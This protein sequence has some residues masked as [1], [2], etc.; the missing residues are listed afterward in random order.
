MDTQVS[1]PNGGQL[2]SYGCPK[3]CRYKPFVLGADVRTAAAQQRSCAGRRQSTHSSAKGLERAKSIAI[4]GS[5]QSAVVAAYCGVSPVSALRGVGRS[6]TA[7]VRRRREVRRGRPEHRGKPPRRL[8]GGDSIELGFAPFKRS[9]AQ[10]QL[11][12]HGA[13]VPATRP[14]PMKC[15]GHTMPAHDSP[16]RPQCLAMPGVRD[17]LPEGDQ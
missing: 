13:R 9:V 2:R 10:L 3:H 16:E 14:T 6:S 4:G 11:V 5:A 15:V 1:V 7:I 17:A 12:A 8:G